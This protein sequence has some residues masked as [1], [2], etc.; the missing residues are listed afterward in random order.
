MRI[1]DSKPSLRWLAPA[2]FALVV[3]GG[4]LVAVNANAGDKLP[5]RT[6]EQL[7]VDLQAAKVDGL[8]GT[9]VQQA[10]LGIPAIPGAGRGE[11]NKLNTLISGKHTLHVWYASPDKSRVAL[12]ETYGESDVITNG[13]DV[14]TWSSQDKAATH[15]TIDHGDHP[16]AKQRSTPADLPKTPKEA[17]QW[18]LQ[19]IEPSTTVTSDSDVTIAGRSAYELVL[20]PKDQRSLM[21]EVRVAIDGTTHAPLR[22]QGFGKKAQLVFEVAYTNVDFTAPEARYFDFNPPA[23]TKVTEA[24][25][26]KH[27]A[28]SG[29]DKAEAQA[30]A[31]GAQDQVTTVGTG[32]TT[33]AVTKVPAG[34]AQ[35]GNEQLQ[36]F[37]KNLE[38]ISGSWGTGRLLRGTAFSAILTDDGRVA[39]GAVGPDLLSEALAK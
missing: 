8:S 33:V 34:T 11:D 35:S 21:T 17:A 3:A 24:A 31:K 25:T 2:A 6:A 7:L 12:T 22:V 18:V 26:P 30:K 36:G 23:G 1:F 5:T 16:A 39:V 15:R 19:A 29:A 13:P 27:P 14:W 38:Q 32:W 20:R 37:M 10:N 4:G 28:P 9:V